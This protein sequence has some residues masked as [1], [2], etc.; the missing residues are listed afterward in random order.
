ME[1]EAETCGRIN[2]IGTALALACFVRATSR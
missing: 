1:T 2:Y